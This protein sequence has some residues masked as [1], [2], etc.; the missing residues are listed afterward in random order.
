MLGSELVNPQTDRSFRHESLLE[1]V[2]DWTGGCRAKPGNSDIMEPL[3]RAGVITSEGLV[4][5]AFGIEGTLRRDPRV[6]PLAEAQLAR[7]TYEF[8]LVKGA[9][10][11]LIRHAWKYHKVRRREAKANLHEL[12]AECRSIMRR[13]GMQPPGEA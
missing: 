13:A 9:R 2:K 1:L 8:L 12:Q 11:R 7:I 6:P 3:L 5:L 4:K 10:A